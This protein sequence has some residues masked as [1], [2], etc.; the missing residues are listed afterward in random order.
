MC[1]N[2]AMRSNHKE[3]IA[4]AVHRISPIHP[5]VP[6]ALRADVYDPAINR[7]HLVERTL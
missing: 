1:E 2:G 5:P 4:R 7:R 6:S 3:G